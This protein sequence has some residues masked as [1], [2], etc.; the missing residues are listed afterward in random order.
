MLVS[1]WGMSRKVSRGQRVSEAIPEIAAVA[2]TRQN[3][4]I[5]N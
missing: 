5:S 4:L 3:E 1:F 2:A